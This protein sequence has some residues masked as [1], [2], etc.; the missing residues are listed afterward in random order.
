MNRY[1]E[2]GY[3]LCWNQNETPHLGVENVNKTRKIGIF[4]FQMIKLKV[5]PISNLQVVHLNV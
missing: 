4:Y 2:I 5:V 1:Y 3:G